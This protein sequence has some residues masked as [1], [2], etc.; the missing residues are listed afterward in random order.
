MKT[1]VQKL[2][3][4][5]LPPA[6]ARFR[7]AFLKQKYKNHRPLAICTLQERLLWNH[8]SGYWT[9]N[10]FIPP[11]FSL[12]NECC[13]GCF[14]INSFSVLLLP[15]IHYS[16]LRRGSATAPFHTLYQYSQHSST[17]HWKG[18]DKYWYWLGRYLRIMERINT[19]KQVAPAK[20]FFMSCDA[21]S[22]IVGKLNDWEC[23][24]FSIVLCHLSLWKKQHEW[25]K[26]KPPRNCLHLHPMLPV[27][28][29]FL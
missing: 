16:S 9:Q 10:S 13:F 11:V 3:E 8:R 4:S 21:N 18:I 2:Y 14:I 15:V 17:S 6:V 1:S 5:T 28:S 26:K 7:H 12:T 25:C 24:L 20:S 23:F 22:F 29:I 27:V 19:N